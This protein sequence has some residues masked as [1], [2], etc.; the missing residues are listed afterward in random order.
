MYLFL[1]SLTFEVKSSIKAKW[2]S[3]IKTI[4]DKFILWFF[5]PP[6]LT[7]YFDTFLKPGRVFLVSNIPAL[8][9]FIILTNWF[10]VV[11]I[12]ESFCIKFKA[13]LSP[14][15]NGAA[16][17]LTVNITSPFFTD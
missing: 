13:V 10:V 17:P 2:L 7:A 5:P 12:P 16:G 6:H 15:S 3:F 4:S 1:I 9:P 11:A 14:A 8:D